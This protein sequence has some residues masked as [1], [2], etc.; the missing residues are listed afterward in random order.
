MGLAHTLPMDAK[1]IWHLYD[2]YMKGWASSIVWIRSMKCAKSQLANITMCEEF[3]GPENSYLNLL[4]E[5]KYLDN[6]FKCLVFVLIECVFSVGITQCVCQRVGSV[7]TEVCIWRQTT[8]G[9]PSTQYIHTT[10]HNTAPSIIHR[11]STTQNTTPLLLSIRKQHSPSTSML[12]SRHPL[13]HTTQL[14][15]IHWQFNQHPLALTQ[16]TA[17]Q[18]TD[19][20]WWWWTWAQPGAGSYWGN[21]GVRSTSETRKA[22]PLQ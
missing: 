1:L 6:L 13:I 3:S 8:T 16:P 10:Q 22:G 2:T 5:I 18:D 12:L 7:Q 4:S 9:W 21:S 11:H 20:E 17:A 14:T 19:A 15:L